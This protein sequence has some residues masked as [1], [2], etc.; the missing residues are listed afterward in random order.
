MNTRIKEIIRKAG[1]LDYDDD[2]NELTPILMGKGL[3]KF[4]E[5][6]IKECV[7]ICEKDLCNRKDD[8][9]ANYFDGGLRHCTRNIKEHFGVE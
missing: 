2:N 4:A 9:P 3:N 6:I 8:P 1:G 7:A 5:L